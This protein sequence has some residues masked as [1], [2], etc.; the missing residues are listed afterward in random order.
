MISFESIPLTGAL[1]GFFLGLALLVT[2]FATR[3][4]FRR[5][6]SQQG[7][8]LL[9]RVRGL[10][11]VAFLA[12]IGLMLTAVTSNGMRDRDG[13]LKP[14]NLSLITKPDGATVVSLSPSD[15]VGEGEVVASFLTPQRAVEIDM[16]ERRREQLLA[17]AEALTAEPLPELFLPPIDEALDR[18]IEQTQALLA[19]TNQTVSDLVALRSELLNRGAGLEGSSGEISSTNPTD[20]GLVGPVVDGLMD[21]PAI[22]KLTSANPLILTD[23]T[24][25]D[26]AAIRAALTDLDARLTNLRAQRDALTM[27]VAVMMLRQE[28]KLDARQAAANQVNPAEASRAEQLASLQRQ[29]A[30]LGVTIASARAETMVKAPH[31]A[32]IIFRNDAPLPGLGNPLI[33]ALTRA[34]VDAEALGSDHN[35]SGFMACLTLHQS[36]ID[37][38]IQSGEPVIFRVNAAVETPFFE[39]VYQYHESTR[40]SASSPLVTF[41]AKPSA[42]VI[43]TL[44]RNGQPLTISLVSVP[45]PFYGTPVLVS[46]GLMVL[47]VVLFM[48]QS[49]TRALW[50]P[51]KSRAIGSQVSVKAGTAVMR[52]SN[53]EQAPR[54]DIREVPALNSP[55]PL[56]LTDRHQQ[57]MIALAQQFKLHIERGTLDL[58]LVT[59]LEW[60]IDRYPQQAVEALTGVLS[61]D[62]ETL[63]DAL[64]L[65]ELEPVVIRRA[66]TILVLVRK[67]TTSEPSKIG[68]AAPEDM[69][70]SRL[71][72]TFSPNKQR[73]Q[74]KVL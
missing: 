72:P 15:E 70:E 40:G 34:V 10:S 52:R 27:E 2:V 64:D 1:T 55:M 43:E 47:A 35:F 45:H 38:L 51:R 6:Q 44:L 63:R 4:W 39:A 13:I 8:A 14:V 25:Q 57:K 41:Q 65:A 68:I 56:K 3:V 54:V 62:L 9:G 49:L 32:G 18:R 30:D 24:P 50:R 19:L 53:K 21:A 74:P 67:V 17:E 36:E 16:L 7:R 73:L 33:L 46:I 48:L 58:N 66:R 31:D 26:L 71:N 69:L 28:V 11:V 60:M 12:G 23:E 29:A 59:S 42:E 22:Q 5:N 37:R 61:D 20:V